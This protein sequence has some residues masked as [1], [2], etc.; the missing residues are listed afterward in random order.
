MNTNF[1]SSIRN[2]V[3]DNN[4]DVDFSI[5][6]QKFV[7]PTNSSEH[8]KTLISQRKISPSKEDIFKSDLFE[9]ID[10][11]SYNNVFFIVYCEDLQEDVAKVIDLAISRAARIGQKKILQLL[12]DYRKQS[13]HLEKTQNKSFYD[14]LHQAICAEQIEIIKY[15]LNEEYHS[16]N[17]NLDKQLAKQH[18]Q[19]IPINQAV[20]VGNEKIVRY[21]IKKSA[22]IDGFYG[23]KSSPIFHATLK[24]CN[25]IL[26]LLLEKGANP[27][28]FS[29]GENTALYQASIR[30][31]TEA[32]CMLLEAGADA[33]SFTTGADTPI[34]HAAINECTDIIKMLLFC[35]ADPD[36]KA[37]GKNTPLY[38]A[39]DA[40]KIKSVKMLLS[41]ALSKTADINAFAQG[42]QTPLYCAA[43]KGYYDIVHLL[44]IKK[45]NV[46]AFATGE[47]TPIFIA[48][49]NNHVEIVKLLKIYG[50]MQ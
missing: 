16:V 14:P 13:F 42:K 19:L 5:S 25:K 34:F 50:A 28:S 10:S 27:D 6:T 2:S 38:G 1:D 17:G 3:F 44:L 46:N 35:N 20:I 43:K 33:N 41:K 9:Y 29:T 49:Q 12:S 31:N 23:A 39:V 18:P 24:G 47:D 21:L 11:D 8:K 22:R 45:A 37:K 48:N 40:N 30:G 15:L 36:S 4:H 26:K 7:I 32:V